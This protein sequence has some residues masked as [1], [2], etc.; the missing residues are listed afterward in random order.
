MKLMDVFKKT[1]SSMEPLKLTRAAWNKEDRVK[2]IYLSSGIFYES[3]PTHGQGDYE[4]FNL[5]LEDLLAFDWSFAKE[6]W[7]SK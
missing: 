7:V 4:R 1:N 6:T 2:S 5:T 3:L